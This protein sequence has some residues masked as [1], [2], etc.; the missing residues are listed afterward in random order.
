[1]KKACISGRKYKIIKASVNYQHNLPTKKQKNQLPTKCSLHSHARSPLPLLKKGTSIIPFNQQLVT[2]FE[3]AVLEC[4]WDVETR[5][6]ILKETE[7]IAAKIN[8]ENEDED[9]AVILKRLSSLFEDGLVQETRLHYHTKL[10]ISAIGMDTQHRIK[11][12]ST[13]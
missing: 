6:F 4:N 2:F 3:S 1:M 10:T 5:S 12:V 13:V 8:E 9:Q 11:H 7:S